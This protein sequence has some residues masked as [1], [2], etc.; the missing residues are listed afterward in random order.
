MAQEDLVE[1]VAGTL[2]GMDNRTE[3]V[4]LA[5]HTHTHTGSAAS[6][7]HRKK[8]KRTLTTKRKRE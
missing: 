5:R 8:Q 7:W 3:K 1:N 6:L 2:G 4:R